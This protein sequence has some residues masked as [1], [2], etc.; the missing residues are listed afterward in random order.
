MERWVGGWMDGKIGGWMDV[1]ILS[2]HMYVL[3]CPSFKPTYL[4]TYLP[5]YL[6][7]GPIVYRLGPIQCVRPE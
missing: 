3:T 6:P 7:R 4:H 5:T 1:Y 2:I